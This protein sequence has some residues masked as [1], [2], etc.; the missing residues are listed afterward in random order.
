[1]YSDA[2]MQYLFGLLDGDLADV[3]AEDEAP[4]AGKRNHVVSLRS[5][6]PQAT[7]G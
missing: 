4:R 3:E 1:M 5:S 2:C 6:W 7:R